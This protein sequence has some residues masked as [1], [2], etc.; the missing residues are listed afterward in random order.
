MNTLF[1]MV[2][3]KKLL[4]FVVAATAVSAAPLEKRIAQV[5]ADSTADWE[6]A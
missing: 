3:F 4:A 1:I 2:Q 5:I 6:Q